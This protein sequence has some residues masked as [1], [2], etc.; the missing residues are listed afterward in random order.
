MFEHLVDKLPSMNDQ[1]QATRLVEAGRRAVASNDW[2]E[3]RTLVGR[4]WDLVPAEEQT[5]QDVRLYTGLV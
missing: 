4:L 3:L 5:A 1:I 2:E